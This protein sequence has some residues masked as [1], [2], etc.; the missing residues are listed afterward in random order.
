MSKLNLAGSSFDFGNVLFAVL[1]E[2]EHRRGALPEDEDEARGRLME[3]AR[4]KLE[5]IHQSYVESGGTPSYWKELAEEVLDNA[6]PQYAMA[7][8]QQTRLER[9]GYDLWRGGDAVARGVLGL[10]GLA[11]G[12]LFAATRFTPIPVDTFVYVAWALGGGG[13]FWP[14]VKRMVTDYRHARFLNK[15]IVQAEKYQKDSRIHYVSSKQ[16]DEALRS[17]GPEEEGEGEEP[18]P[19]A[20][21]RRMGG[22][23]PE[24]PEMDFT[25]SEINSLDAT[26]N[27]RASSARSEG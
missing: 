15:L 11:L 21:K 6:M 4:D 13:F 18:A 3:I 5:E 2:C 14:E 8:L 23:E 25:G 22:A 20:E 27:T 24:G 1:Q 19:E 16:F 7:A 17:L 12:G 10:G 26:E 9:S